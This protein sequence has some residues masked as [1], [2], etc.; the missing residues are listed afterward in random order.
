MSVGEI[1]YY[2]V[3]VI[4]FIAFAVLLLVLD[5]KEVSREYD[6]YI[7]GNY[8]ERVHNVRVDHKRCVVRFVDKLDGEW[9]VSYENLLMVTLDD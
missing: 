1:I 4:L 6:L 7:D 8:Y 3:L 9:S 5:H 2:S